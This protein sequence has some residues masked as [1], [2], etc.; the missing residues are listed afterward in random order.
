MKRNQVLICSPFAFCSQR[1]KG[2]PCKKLSIIIA[3][4]FKSNFKSVMT[5]SANL[6]VL[7]ISNMKK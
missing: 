7:E 3:Q 5:F 2:R 1:V 4:L 6:K